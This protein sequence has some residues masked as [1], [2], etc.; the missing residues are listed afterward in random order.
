MEKP[1][2]I[3]VKDGS[4]V[5]TF[6]D[7]EVLSITLKYLRDE[8]PCA[9]CKGETILFRT[10]RPAQLPVYTPEMYK[11]KAL[12]VVGDYALKVVWKDGHDTGLYTWD[13]LQQLSAGQSNSDHNIY[14]SLV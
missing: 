1:N 10:Y 12:E 9:N 4:I 7:G 3:A 11:V 2:K 6:G 8:C 14:D 5:L 13:Y